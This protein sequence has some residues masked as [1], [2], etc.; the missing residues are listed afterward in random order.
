MTAFSEAT[1]AI[2]FSLA[3]PTCFA[4]A[5]VAIEDPLST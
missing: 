4:V 3:G 2:G 5:R 1:V